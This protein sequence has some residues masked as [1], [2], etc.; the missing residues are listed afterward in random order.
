MAFKPGGLGLTM[1]YL[2]LT[3]ITL[4]AVV[5]TKYWYCMDC[6]YIKNNTT[7]SGKFSNFTN[8]LKLY[9]CKTLL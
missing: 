9:Y 1:D 4:V 7:L 3:I 8:P 5:R 2:F 6:K